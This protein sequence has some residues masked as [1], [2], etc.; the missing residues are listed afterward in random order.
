MIIENDR[1][2]ILHANKE[3]YPHITKA[4]STIKDNLNIIEN[5]YIQNKAEYYLIKFF[6]KLH[7]SIEKI[8]PANEDEAYQ[9][10][11]E[12]LTTYIKKDWQYWMDNL[13]ITTLDDLDELI[14]I[15][16]LSGLLINEATTNNNAEILFEAYYQVQ[17]RLKKENLLR[18]E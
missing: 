7:Q 5:A 9:D 14:H 1:L 6:Q 12:A 18:G 15:I 11:L 4:E 8:S 16:K 10:Y 17:S 13:K 2:E 3:L